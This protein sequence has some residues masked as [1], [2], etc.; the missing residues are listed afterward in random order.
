MDLWRERKIWQHQLSG[1]QAFTKVGRALLNSLRT[2]VDIPLIGRPCQRWGTLL[3]GVQYCIHSGEFETEMR[4]S[5]PLR[6]TPCVLAEGNME[7]QVQV[8]LSSQTSSAQCAC[9]NSFQT[10]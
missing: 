4:N 8:L 9:D 1:Q 3:P 2:V 5:S 6:Y 10:D 7:I